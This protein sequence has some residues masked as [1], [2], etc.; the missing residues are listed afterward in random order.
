M[1]CQ[2][3]HIRA[4]VVGAVCPAIGQNIHM[5]FEGVNTDV[6]QC[7]LDYL[8]EAV[9]NAPG[10]RRLLIADNASW[11]KSKKLNWYHFESQFLPLTVLTSIRLNGYGCE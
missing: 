8:A 11:H 3:D 4:S 2:G 6:F 7:Y 5:I 10:V 9:P 1:P